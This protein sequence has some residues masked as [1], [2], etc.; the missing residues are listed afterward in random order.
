[1]ASRAEC[2]SVLVFDFE[3]KVVVGVPDRRGGFLVLVFEFGF[4]TDSAGG[5][6]V[7]NGE[8][9]PAEDGGGF[10]EHDRAGEVVIVLCVGIGSEGETIVELCGVSEFQRVELFV[11]DI[12]CGDEV[13]AEEATTDRDSARIKIAECGLGCAERFGGGDAEDVVLRV[14]ERVEECDAS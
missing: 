3:I 4:G 7:V 9:A 6:D 1:M 11:V 12:E 8:E 2:A 5:P 13:D 14:I 10:R